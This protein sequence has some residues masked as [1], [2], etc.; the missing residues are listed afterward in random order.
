MTRI[1]HP[2]E[3]LLPGA[4]A[5]LSALVGALAMWGFTVDDALISVRYA[6]NLAAG[7][8]WRFDLGGPPTD[9]VTP[10]PWP[11]FVAPLGRLAPLS[12]LDV[13]RAAGGAAWVASAL[14][15]GAALGRSVRPRWLAL[16]LAL[17]VG[18]SLPLAAHAVS[19]METAFATLLATLAVTSTTRPWRAAAL[20]GAAATLR[21]EL[22]P[23]ACALGLG[24]G[25]AATAG[26]A[27]RRATRGILV[28][29]AASAPPL[30]VAA[31]RLVAFG[32]PY[33]LAL[34]AKPSDLAHGAT[35]AAAALL[36]AGAP[37]LLAAPRSIARS[38]R[39]LAI[40]S[41][42]LVHVG[43]VALVGGD[44]MPYARLVVPVLPGLWI[45]AGEIADRAPPWTTVARAA[46]ASAVGLTFFVRAGP[47]GRGVARDRAELVRIAGPALEGAACVAT[48]DAGW[49]GA[50]APRARIVDLAGVTDPEIAALPG[51]HTS[52]RVDV[53]MLVARGA[54]ALVVYAPR[55]EAAGPARVAELRL[56]SSPLF[57]RRFAR[58]EFLP[59]GDG[60]G[61]YVLYR[62]RP[63]PAPEP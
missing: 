33:P 32:A 56:V 20:A 22:A 31:A 44:W 53:G 52:K 46:V 26:D 16:A 2:R 30:T 6:H 48:L 19:G 17:T 39:A 47:A 59:L 35:Y 8:G 49:V 37:A 25:A 60:G 34:R 10:L 62:A 11:V 50:A 40:T 57:E 38:P 54:D 18:T 12:A 36:V 51:G 21:P 23:W 63:R 55:G 42:F 24:A 5:A 43:V 27:A 58:A 14:R 28:A 15:V 61:G 45:V 1:G 13:L 29:I 9:G 4:A 3:A 41:A 7:H